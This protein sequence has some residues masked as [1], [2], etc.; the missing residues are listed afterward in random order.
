MV[1]LYSIRKN[2]SIYYMN[3]FHK[4]NGVLLYFLHIFVCGPVF[5]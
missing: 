2:Q 1:G 3:A 4:G 5:F